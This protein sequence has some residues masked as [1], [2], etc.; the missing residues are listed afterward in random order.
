MIK[1][2]KY[3]FLIFRQKAL[4]MARGLYPS[5]VRLGGK[6][7]NYLKFGKELFVDNNTITGL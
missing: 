4:K 6:A 2:L 7:T 5:F 3:N 1:K